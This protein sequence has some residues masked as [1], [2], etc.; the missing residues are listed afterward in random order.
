MSEPTPFFQPRLEAAYREALSQGT[1][2]LA[3]LGVRDEFGNA[4]WQLIF[5][6]EMDALTYKLESE[7][8]TIW[9]TCAVGN[10]EYRLAA[11][12]E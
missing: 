9:F 2:D 5:Q 8:F 12:K 7:G 11:R 1:V 10:T 4:S 3:P 6:T